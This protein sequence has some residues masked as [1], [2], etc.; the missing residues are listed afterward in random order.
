MSAIARFVFRRRGGKGWHWT[1]IVTWVWLLGGLLVMF[2]PAVWL[3][4]SCL[5]RLLQLRCST[6][7]APSQSINE[8]NTPSICFGSVTTF[9]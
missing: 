5:N 2:G 9:H 8:Y 1:D 4:T 6:S 3:V 7:H